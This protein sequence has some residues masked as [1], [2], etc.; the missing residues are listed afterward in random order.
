MNP[1][2]QHATPALPESGEILGGRFEVLDE[3]GDGG[4]GHVYRV[5]DR[6]KQREVALKL[7]LPRYVGRD[8][9][10]RRFFLEAT[11]GQRIGRHP[12]IVQILESG[13][14]SDRNEWPFITMELVEGRGL[15]TY[16]VLHGPMSPRRAATIARQVAA[17][18]QAIHACEVVHRDISTTNVVLQDEGVVLIDFS[19]AGDLRSP[20]MA[21]GQGGRL[22]QPHEIIG[23]H[24]CMAPEQARAEPPSPAM[25]VYAFGIMLFE[26]LT[27]HNPYEDSAR[28]SF[29]PLL[30]DGKILPPRVKDETIP[31]PLA[32]LVTACTDPNPVA[33]PSVDEIVRKLDEVLA[34]MGVP[35]LAIVTELAPRAVAVVPSPTAAPPTSISDDGISDAGEPKPN[36]WRLVAI[37]SIFVA[38]VLAVII[39]VLLRSQDEDRAPEGPMLQSGDVVADVDDNASTGRPLTVVPADADTGIGASTGTADDLGPTDDEPTSVELRADV[40]PAAVEEAPR[41]EPDPEPMPKP[42]RPRP[43]VDCEEQRRRASRGDLAKSWTSVLRATRHAECWENQADRKELRVRA[44]LNLRRYDECAKVSLRSASDEVERMIAFCKAASKKGEGRP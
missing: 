43:S 6:K 26:L 27:G 16:L 20:R 14:L 41:V 17:A 33:R 44:L 25:D 42:K 4:M 7:L 30:I 19:H 8:D 21:A 38:A 32:E 31:G 13:R 28:D 5:L 2:V 15:P 37:A 12:H 23:T 34:T 11:L 3:L 1:A 22:T 10:E 24:T 36:P 9:R 35:P 18:M 39:A 29:L 40:P